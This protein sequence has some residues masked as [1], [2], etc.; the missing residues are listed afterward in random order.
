MRELRHRTQWRGKGLTCADA[1][2]A[3]TRD[4]YRPFGR[5]LPLNKTSGGRYGGGRE[6]T[7]W[8]TKGWDI[9]LLRLV[10]G[11]VRQGA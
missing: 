5:G 8:E 7:K 2:A 11:L 6:R 10:Y 1:S 9:V 4:F 3:D